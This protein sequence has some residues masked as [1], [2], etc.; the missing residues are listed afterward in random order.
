MR[1]IPGVLAGLCLL[2][3]GC[4]PKRIA[5]E[6]VG[7]ADH[8]KAIVLAGKGDRLLREGKD[9]LALLKYTEASFLDP[10]EERIFNKLALAYMRVSQVDNAE[11][12]VKRSIGL[13]FEY[14]LARNTWGIIQMAR[15]DYK[16]AIRSLQTAIRLQEKRPSGKNNPRIMANFHVN[17]GKAFL[18]NRKVEA[19][20][21]SYRKAL[22]LNPDALSGE[23]AISL[24]Y[25]SPTSTDPET[26]F[27]H[28]KAFARLGSKA[29]TLYY[30]NR[31][32]S[33][34]L[35][36]HERLFSDKDF[37]SLLQDADFLRL[38]E[39]YEISRVN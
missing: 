27:A 18:E 30:L 32:L 5:K 8:I 28:A 11:K 26:Q 34:G 1:W 15:L 24:H 16:G 33:S 2:L 19:A 3:S 29:Q 22:E 17:L 14:P 23:G 31:A 37:Q 25:A 4:G 12:A 21:R 36:R 39:R 7:S 6:P 10:F 9:H 38:L 20:I 13:N 35:R